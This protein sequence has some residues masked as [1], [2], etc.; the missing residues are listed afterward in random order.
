M[1][2]KDVIISETKERPRL[3]EVKELSHRIDLCF[4]FK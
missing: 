2:Y 4:K 1:N 3:S